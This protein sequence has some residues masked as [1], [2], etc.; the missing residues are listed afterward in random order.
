MQRLMA[1]AQR[2]TMARQR[3]IG[4]VNDQRQM[5]AGRRRQQ[6]QAAGQIRGTQKTGG[7]GAGQGHARRRR[8][9]AT[10]AFGRQRGQGRTGLIDT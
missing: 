7:A 8:Q 9:R 4:D 2:S 10:R 3:A 1:A 5:A 6:I